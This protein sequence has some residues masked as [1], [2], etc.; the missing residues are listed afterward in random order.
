M[1]NTLLWLVTLIICQACQAQGQ[2]GPSETLLAGEQA[3]H[4]GN[5]QEAIRQFDVILQKNPKQ[6]R[7]LVLRSNAKY[8]LR[9]YQGA[10]QDAQQVLAINPG[11]FS[12]Q[13]YTALLNLG[14]TYNSL[15]QFDQARRYFNQAKKAD[16][17]DIRMYEGIGYSFLE[18]QNY[19]A[20]LA[21]FT[22]S[23]TVNPTSKTSFYGIGKVHM[24]LKQYPQAIQ[25][26]DQAIKLDPSY[27]M[28]YQNRATAKYQ[29][30]DLAGCCADLQR[31]QALG[32]DN[33][34]VNS[35]RD[36]VCH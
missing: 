28:A 31:C 11:Q 1:K 19:P 22:Q 10:I 3:L 21:E 14:I 12:E 26:Y 35:F 30:Q 8:K 5:S 33:A 23:V 6:E 34:A 7:A 32:V 16:S 17:T 4:A 13:D 20:A 9:D 18:E 36:Q 2:Q 24:L 29:A 25:A 15:R 27:A